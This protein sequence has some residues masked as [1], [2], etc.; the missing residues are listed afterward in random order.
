MTAGGDPVRREPVDPDVDLHD[1]AQRTPREVDSALLGA[2][3]AGGVLGSEA[4]YALGRALPHGAGSWPLATFLINVSGCL[5]IGVLMVVLTEVVRP[6]RL[7]RPFLGVGVLGGW[8]TFST[9][10]VDVVALARAGRPLPAAAYL[11][12]TALAALLAVVLGSSVTRALTRRS[13]P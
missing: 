12:G 9:A 5:L 4:R 2:I 10:M 13:P 3:A 11:L 6:H 8:T 1:A 7:A